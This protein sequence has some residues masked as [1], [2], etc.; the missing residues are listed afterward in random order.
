MIYNKSFMMVRVLIVSLMTIVFLSCAEKNSVS[1]ELIGKTIEF[2]DNLTQINTD[3]VPDS[4]L[5][6]KKN[7]TVL[8]ISDHVQCAPCQLQLIRWKRLI[9]EYG[10]YIDFKFI[11][12]VKNKYELMAHC[13]QMG[14]KY[15]L[16][17]DMKNEYCYSDVY[18]Q[19]ISYRCFILDGDNKVIFVGNP[20]HITKLADEFEALLRKFEKD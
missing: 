9:E 8:V 3:S 1:K 12:P 2:S 6:S 10:D 11:I 19:D 13:K 14:F 5:N 16:L 7:A 15:P 20:L 4:Y 17:V 18:P